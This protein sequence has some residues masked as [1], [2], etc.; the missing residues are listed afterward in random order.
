MDPSRSTSCDALLSEVLE[1]LERRGES[2]RRLA[3]EIHRDPE[4]GCREYH[5]AARLAGELEEEGFQVVTG[6]AGMDTAFRAERGRGAPAVAFLVEYDAVPEMGHA[7]G[8]NLIAAVSLGAAVALGQVVDRLGGRVVVIGAPA[9]ETVGGKVVLAVRGA[10]DDL[11]AALL[12][13]PGSENC[14]QVRTVAS[15]SM[16]V[17]SSKGVLP[18]PWPPPN[19]ASTPWPAWFACSGPGTRCSQ[20]WAKTSSHRV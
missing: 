1:Q 17:V 9:E 19:G 2:L 3:A 18:M 10:L 15:W 13:H 16:E 7:C 8:H 5:S 11:D 12:A 20:N 6:L 4:L 14:A